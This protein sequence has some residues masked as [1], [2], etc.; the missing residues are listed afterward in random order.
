MQLKRDLFIESP[1]KI[2]IHL[3]IG[4]KRGDGFHNIE[5]LF[6]MVSLYDDIHIRSLK[7]NDICSIEGSFNC[8]VSDNLIYKAVHIFRERTGIRNGLRISVKK[9][10][11][12]GA[13]LGGGSSNAASVLTGLNMLFCTGLSNIAVAE[14]GQSIGSDIPFFCHSPAAVVSGRGDKVR[15]IRPRLDYY[16]VI[17][18]PGISVNT[19]D[20]YRWYDESG[21]KL[22][23]EDDI[24]TEYSGKSPKGWNFFTSL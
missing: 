24:C 4:R 1:A 13:G 11:P 8:S 20:A 17:I 6:Q 19:S 12:A 2:N 9:R 15:K 7:D 3:E 23:F 18:Y 14:M 10:I 5:S 16:I 21:E 22:S